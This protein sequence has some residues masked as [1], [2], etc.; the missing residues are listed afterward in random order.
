METSLFKVSIC[1]IKV[2]T[3]FQASP[4]IEQT[5][6]AFNSK[7]L[8]WKLSDRNRQSTKIGLKHHLFIVHTFTLKKL[9]IETYAFTKVQL[10]DLTSFIC[11]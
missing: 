7:F 6:Y 2:F 11:L 1:T 9:V 10:Y 8:D 3:S 4:G 5:D